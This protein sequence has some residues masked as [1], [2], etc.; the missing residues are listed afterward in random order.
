KQYVS[1]TWDFG[2]WQAVLANTYQTSYVDQQTD[3]DGNNRQVGSLSIWDLQASYSGLKN[4]KFT[5]GVKNLFDTNP[6]VSNQQSVF[7]VGFDPS[8]YDPRARFVYG[9]VTFRWK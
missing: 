6:P 8:Y 9:T 1:A 5:V 2:P 3:L 7:I 4:W